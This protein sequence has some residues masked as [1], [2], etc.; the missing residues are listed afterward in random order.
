MIHVMIDLETTG[1]EPGCCILSIGAATF[2]S[3]LPNSHYFY[4]RI[5]HQ[6][7]L[8]SGFVDDTDTIRWWKEQSKD[9]Y[10]EAFGGTAQI[11][12]ALLNFEAYLLGLK[13][14][15]DV[16][17]WGNGAD[18]DN[19]ILAAAYK[20]LDLFVPW[21]YRDNRCYRTLRNL[22]PYVK[23]LPFEGTKHTALADATNQAA[24]AEALLGWI[25]RF[26][27]AKNL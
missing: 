26:K 7:S 19:V 11:R 23:A 6:S 8:D 17:V 16:A 27:E 5:S 18:F 9:A 4:E 24:H 10:N 1:K 21:D 20:K 13:K 14:F 3:P 22:L 12:D 25:D 15:G 2:Y